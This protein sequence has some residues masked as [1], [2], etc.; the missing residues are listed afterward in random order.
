MSTPTEAVAVKAGPDDTLP[1]YRHLVLNWLLAHH[2]G[3][4]LSVEGAPHGLSWLEIP[5]REERVTTATPRIAAPW[6]RRPGDFEVADFTAEVELDTLRNQ[7]FLSEVVLCALAQSGWRRGDWA[8]VT[9]GELLIRFTPEGL[10]STP[11][12]YE[13]DLW[14]E[15]NRIRMQELAPSEL[16]AAV[17]PFLAHA[18]DPR[19]LEA[20]IMLH[21]D[22]VGSLRELADRLGA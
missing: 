21:V 7:G 3:V 15:F 13:P 12:R 4:P 8:H 18:G 16:L 9:R 2:Y 22:E 10:L 5:H 19:E 20:A 14:H 6:D 17:R 1:T 11:T